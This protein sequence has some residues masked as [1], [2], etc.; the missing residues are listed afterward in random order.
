MQTRWLCADIIQPHAFLRS[1]CLRL[2]EDSFAVTTF[3]ARMIL[4]AGQGRVG[5]HVTN[6]LCQFVSIVLYLVD[7]NTHVVC[8][9]LIVTVPTRI[10][11]SSALLVLLWIEHVVAF[12][13]EFDAD[14]S[15][16]IRRHC[17]PQ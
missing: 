6:N 17:L 9:L 13:A 3:L 11:Q 1:A 12:L 14:K 8:L 2:E 4:S 16:T 15:W 5:N 7:V 10:Q